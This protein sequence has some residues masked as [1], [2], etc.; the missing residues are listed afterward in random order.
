VGGLRVAIAIVALS[1]LGAA[2]CG[3]SKQGPFT[4]PKPRAAPHNWGIASIPTGAQLAYPPG[5]QRIRSDTGTATAALTAADGRFL[6]Y[7]NVTPQQGGEKLTGW[8]SFRTAHNAHEGDSNV[9]A[10]AAATGLHFL[11]G[12]GSCVKDAYATKTAAHYIEIACIVK[13]SKS[14]SVVVGAATSGSW[15]QMAP[16]LERA[17]SGFRT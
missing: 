15:A 2:A 17:I 16:V 11:S 9:T 7:L 10:L 12:P 14:T 6:G 4:W 8:A 5:W 1:L 13:G 3:G